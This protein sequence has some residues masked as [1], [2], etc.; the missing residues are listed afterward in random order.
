MFPKVLSQHYLYT[1]NAWLLLCP[2]WLSFDWAL[3]SI[4]LVEHVTDLRCIAIA[5][6]L[7]FL[8]GCVLSMQRDTLLA[9]ALLIVPFLPA[10][11]IVSVGFVVAERVL[12]IPSMGFCAL[13]ALGLDKLCCLCKERR[14]VRLFS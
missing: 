1:L 3:G 10:S 4:Q 12:Y 11:G 2:D 14:N 13:V 8:S 9:L 7:L 5:A 6:F